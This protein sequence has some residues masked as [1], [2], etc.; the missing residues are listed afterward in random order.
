LTV[1]RS[2]Q[3]LRDLIQEV[4]PDIVHAMRIPY[5]GML[6]AQAYQGLSGSKPSFLVSIW[7]NDFTLHAPSTPLM[8]YYTRLTVKTVRC[9]ACR[10]GT[11]CAACARMGLQRDKASRWW[12]PVT[13]ESEA[14][15]F[16]RLQKLVKNPIIINPRGVRALCAQ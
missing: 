4:Q 16:I 6:T 13:A 10:C 12:H 7:G 8:R 15:F 1:P 3:K 9:A 11:R 14:M 5:E 2:A